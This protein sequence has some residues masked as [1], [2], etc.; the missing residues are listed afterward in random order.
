MKE[1]SGDMLLL[2]TLHWVAMCNCQNPLHQTLKLCALQC[3]QV[4][5]QLL[6]KTKKSFEKKYVN[7][8]HKNRLEFS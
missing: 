1:L 8:L 4:L 2:H 7:A 3:V 5:S 6:K